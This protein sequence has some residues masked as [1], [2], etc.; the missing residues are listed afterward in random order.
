MDG[1]M[2]QIGEAAAR[3]GVS[4][5]TLRYYE[6]RGLIARPARRPSGYRQYTP[7]VVRLIRLI[8]WAQAIGFTLEEIKEMV[9]LLDGRVRTPTTRVRARAA[10][11]INEIDDRM[12]QL[13]AM[14]DALQ[15]IVD[16]SC[17][18]SCPIISEAAAPTAP[19]VGGLN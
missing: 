1:R 17:E 11:K 14:R 8:K 9:D 12:R 3:S 2:L 7:E 19:A 4:I 15:S 13:Q 18:G 5:Q 10:A 6:R 16:C